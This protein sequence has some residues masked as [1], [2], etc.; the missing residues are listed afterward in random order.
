[1]TNKPLSTLRINTLIMKEEG[2]RDTEVVQALRELLALRERLRFV[3]RKSARRKREIRR[4]YKAHN[5]WLDAFYCGAKQR[6]Q[7]VSND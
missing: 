2:Y 3:S 1:M 6:R 5:M 7:R 4:V